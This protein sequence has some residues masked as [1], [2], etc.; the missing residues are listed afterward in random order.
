MS[1]LIWETAA[2][3]VAVHT[4]LLLLSATL[5]KVVLMRVLAGGGTQ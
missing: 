3:F 4:F 2:A 1:I 5:S